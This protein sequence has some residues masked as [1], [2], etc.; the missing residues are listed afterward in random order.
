MLI[1]NRKL[2]AGERQSNIAD[3]AP[4]MLELFGIPSPKYMD[5]DSLLSQGAQAS[6]KAKSSGAKEAAA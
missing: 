2:G 6:G 5:G 3:M 1:S 4:T